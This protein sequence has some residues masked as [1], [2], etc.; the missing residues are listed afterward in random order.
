MT[1]TRTSIGWLTGARFARTVAVSCAL[2]VAGCAADDVEFNGKIFDAVG[3]NQKTKSAEP[4]M[5]ARTPLVMPPSADRVPEPGLPPEG[6]AP[7]V[8][9]LADPDAQKKTSRA[10][11]ERQQAEYCKKNYEMAKALGDNDADLATGPL[12]PCKG[13]V[14]TAIKNWTKG[15]DDSVEGQVEE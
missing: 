5:V 11:L 15:D 4:K 9:A 10:E 7:E 8:A 1:R 3:L 12:G 6:Q 14:I 13:S 2:V